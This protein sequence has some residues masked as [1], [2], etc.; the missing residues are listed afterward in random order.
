MLYWLKKNHEQLY[1]LMWICGLRVEPEGQERLQATPT[2]LSR[3]PQLKSVILKTWT[4][5]WTK[6]LYVSSQ[7]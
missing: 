6:S 1:R 3:R 2:S 4:W 7:L 5:T